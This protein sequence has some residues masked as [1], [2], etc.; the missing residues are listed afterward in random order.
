MAGQAYLAASEVTQLA[1]AFVSE[2]KLRFPLQVMYSGMPLAVHSGLDINSP[3]DLARWRAFVYDLEARLQRIPESELR[4]R[5][6]WVTRADLLEGIAQTHT[7]DTCRS[8]LWNITPYGFVFLLPTVADSQ[9]V[10][11]ATNR[12]EALARW[13]GVASWLDRERANLA[14]G[15]R[16]GYAAYRAGAADELSQVEAF[17]A[18]P[19]ADWP[20]TVLARRAKQPQFTLELNRITAHEIIPAAERFRDYLRTQYLPNAR[21][22]PSIIGLPQGMACLRARLSTTTTVDMEPKAMLDALVARRAEERERIMVLARR[23]YDEPDLNWQSFGEKLRHDARDTFQKTDNI[24]VILDN[25]I[26]R[27]RAAWPRMMSTPPPGPLVVRP[28]SVDRYV[29]ASD[30]GERPATYFYSGA[31]AHR[32]VA[33]SLV[34]HE[35]IPGHYLV[36]TVRRQKRSALH[37]IARMIYLGGPNEGWATYAETWA[38]ELGLYSGP[39]EEMGGLVNSV[40]PS[41]VAELGMQVAGWTEVQAGTY[42]RDEAP[43]DL[44]TGDPEGVG[45]IVNQ[46]GDLEAYPIGAMQYEAL[47]KRAQAGL[48]PRFDSREYHQML[49]S[50]GPLPFWALGEK[51]DTWIS[52]QR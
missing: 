51:V 17:I 2:K 16:H 36:D 35:I 21:T 11:T 38:A 31:G 41:A 10:A 18:E 5:K 32:E 34:M 14:L 33:E 4:G 49:L 30:D 50:D 43:F 23:A 47:R 6:E 20:T 25:L 44:P 29:P 8:E 12:R 48:G 37:I 1:D 46:T 28:G 9:P 39:F 22:A 24:P 40:T 7:N 26:A 42:L 27:V 13:H 52:A 15:L 19:Y 45:A 3:E